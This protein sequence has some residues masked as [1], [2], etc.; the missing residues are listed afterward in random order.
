MV[1]VAPGNASPDC[2]SVILPEIVNWAD[3]RTGS[4]KAVNAVNKFFNVY[5]I[6]MLNHLHTRVEYAVHLTCYLSLRR[7]YPDQVHVFEW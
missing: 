1:I 5:K 2:W 3:A 6:K 7:H 4:S